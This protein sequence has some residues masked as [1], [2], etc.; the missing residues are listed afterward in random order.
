M[1]VN[2]MNMIGGPSLSVL[3]RHLERAAR[4]GFVPYREI[5]GDFLRDGEAEVRYTALS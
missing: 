4:D 2:W 3:E 1:K 5:L